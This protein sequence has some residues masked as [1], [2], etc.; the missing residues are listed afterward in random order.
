MSASPEILFMKLPGLRSFAAAFGTECPLVHCKGDVMAYDAD[1]LVKIQDTQL[2]LQRITA[3]ERSSCQAIIPK[4]DMIVGAWY[5]D[6]FGNKTR[7][8]SARE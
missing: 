6:E 3:K 2:R 7:E 4:V 1:T 8:I 5:L